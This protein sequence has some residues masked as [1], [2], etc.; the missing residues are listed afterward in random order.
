M[1]DKNDM[2]IK[3][4]QK[5]LKKL[6]EWSN[7]SLLKLNVDKG[8]QMTVS[9]A[10]IDY[11]ARNYWLYGKQ[12]KMKEEVRDLGVIFDSKFSFDSLNLHK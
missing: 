9:H 12:L 3:T 6:E 5:D 11:T 2:D 4:Q 7:N 1:I 8:V 10:K